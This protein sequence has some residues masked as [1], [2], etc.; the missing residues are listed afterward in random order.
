M[1]LF[2]AL[3]LICIIV[4]MCISVSTTTWPSYLNNRNISFKSLY[5]GELQFHPQWSSNLLNGSGIFMDFMV[6]RWRRRTFSSSWPNVVAGCTE[7]V[8]RDHLS[9]VQFVIH[10]RRLDLSSVR[11]DL[12][13]HFKLIHQIP[14]VCYISMYSSLECLFKVPYNYNYSLINLMQ[15]LA[16]PKRPTKCTEIK[17]TYCGP[18]VVSESAIE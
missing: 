17:W 4:I 1:R 14:R 9:H 5:S 8:S 12:N 11:A 16:Q 6:G 3:P 13:L 10:K 15:R 7:S 2:H 18:C